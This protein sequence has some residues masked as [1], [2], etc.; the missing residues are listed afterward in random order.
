MGRTIFEGEKRV[1]AAFIEQR[2]EKGQERFQTF[3]VERYFVWILFQFFKDN[4]KETPSKFCP[5]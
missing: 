3:G 5:K 1:W 2:Y 4:F